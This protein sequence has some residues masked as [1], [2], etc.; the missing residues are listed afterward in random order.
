MAPSPSLLGFFFASSSKQD[1]IQNPL[2][3]E[4]QNPVSRVSCLCQI[5]AKTKQHKGL[6]R[7]L[8]SLRT[9]WW[10]M[11]GQSGHFL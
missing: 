9:Y 8:P 6:L 1:Q 4:A 2:Q 10:L 5:E 11:V 3:M 7:P